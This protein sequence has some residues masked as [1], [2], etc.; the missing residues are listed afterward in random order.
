MVILRVILVCTHLVR[1]PCP[2]SIGLLW[3]VGVVLGSLICTQLYT[4]TLLGIYYTPSTDTAYY[5]IIHILREVY[6][7]SM[8]RLLHSS[9]ASMVFL[10]VLVHVCRGVFYGSSIYVSSVLSLGVLVYGVLMGIAFLGYVLPWGLMSYWGATVITNLCTGVPC[11]V[12]WILGGF[13]ISNPT[14]TRYFVIHFL[15]PILVSVFLVLHIL[16]VHRIST[17]VGTGYNT[18]NNRVY[19]LI[20]LVVKDTLVLV[21]G[22]LVVLVQVYLGII[23]LAHPDNSLEASVI[24]TPIHIVP[25]WYFLGYYSILKA[26]PG[27][28]SGFLVMI[29]WV[30]AGNIYG[31]SYSASGCTV[32]YPG[33]TGRYTVVFLLVLVVYYSLWIGVQL[34]QGIY[35][36]YGRGYILVSIGCGIG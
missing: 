14:I 32:G 20:W 27:K 7:G 18:S 15:V 25:E 9:G 5:S 1:Y 33:Y 29:A 23:M 10:L 17:S 34:P 31:E 30:I 13:Y 11:M 2:T 6:Y 35:V 19:F 16:Y 28:T 12:P 36:S 3:N 21:Q 24:L 8:Y 26:I 4:G 22:L